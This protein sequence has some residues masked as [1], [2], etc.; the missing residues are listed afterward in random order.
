MEGTD[1]INTEKRSNGGKTEKRD[2]C[3]GRPERPASE[4]TKVAGKFKPSE[5]RV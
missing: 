5:Y 2:S 4:E 1:Q 3:D